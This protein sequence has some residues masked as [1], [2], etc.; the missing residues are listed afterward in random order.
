MK[1]AD[2]FILCCGYYIIFLRVTDEH[3]FAEIKSNLK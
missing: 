3:V 1:R 2:W